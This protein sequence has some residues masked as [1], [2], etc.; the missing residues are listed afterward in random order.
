MN[1]TNL[2]TRTF[3][4]IVIVAALG[5]FVDIYD[6]TLFN[7]VRVPSLKALGFSGD[8]LTSQGIFLQNMQML[9]MV[10][11]G[12]IWGILG[13]KKGRLSVLFFTIL[14]YS[15][16]NIANAYVV[17]ITQYAAMRL[18]AGLGLAGELG[19]GITLISEVMTKETRGKGTTMVGLIGILGA[20]LGYTI[21]KNFSW[22]VAYLV[23]GIQG[24]LLLILRIYVTESGM[25]SKLKKQEVSK[26]NFLMLFTNR[27]RFLK[28]LYCIL[29]G[30]PVWYV[31]GVLVTF[32]SEYAEKNLHIAG[33]IESSKAVMWH[34]VGASIGSL[35]WGLISQWL[36]SRKKSL[37]MALTLLIVFMVAYF[38]SYGVSP[39]LFYGIIFML[40]IAQG[41]WIIFVTVSSEQFGTNLRATVTTTAPNFVRGSVIVVTNLIIF[42]TPYCGGRWNATIYTGIFLVALSLFALYKLKETYGKDLE[43]IES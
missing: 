18:L 3:N 13:D 8:E 24:L 19:A 40:G 34:Y 6:L 22:S 39:S 41:Y 15:L 21:N 14:L 10:I 37:W 28:Y 32:S 9:G 5:Y 43:Y 35:M 17:N 4:A 27:P 38:C 29:L 20:V 11:G 1:S 30:I 36:H 2:T 7:I 33:T 16:A 42:I 23:G 31:I 25:F 12:I 26:G